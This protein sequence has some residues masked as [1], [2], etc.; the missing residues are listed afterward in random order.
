MRRTV[1]GLACSGVRLVS[2]D[3]EEVV[4]LALSDEVLCD[5]AL[6]P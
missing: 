5:A 2:F 6:G 4:G 3:S 1:S